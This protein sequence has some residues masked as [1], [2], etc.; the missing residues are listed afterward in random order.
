MINS[1]ILWCI[2]LTRRYSQ[3]KVIA[4]FFILSFRKICIEKF[5]PWVQ[6][7]SRNFFSTSRISPEAVGFPSQS[8]RNLVNA[9]MTVLS[10]LLLKFFFSWR[11]FSFC[12][13]NSTGKTSCMNSYPFH[14]KVTESFGRFDLHLHC[15]N[16]QSQYR[17]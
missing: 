3:N 13:R 9:I 1:I 10:R 2:I 5:I 8:C 17:D 16:L 11:N 15:T 14:S 12:F 4:I 7:G 6:K